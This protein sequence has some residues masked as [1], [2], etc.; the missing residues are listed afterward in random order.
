MVSKGPNVSV[1]CGLFVDVISPSWME[2]DIVD[3]DNDR[4][5]DNG[6]RC[7]RVVVTPEYLFTR[8]MSS[9]LADMYEDDPVTRRGSEIAG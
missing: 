3:E 9:L 1:L 6:E 7:G 8:R 2:E 5:V 4:D